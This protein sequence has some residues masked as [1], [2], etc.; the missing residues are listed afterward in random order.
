MN[1]GYSFVINNGK[2]CSSGGPGIGVKKQA[3][4]LVTNEP[5]NLR[6]KEKV[7]RKEPAMKSHRNIPGVA[8]QAFTL[9]EL[10]VVMAII[11][12]LAAL[13]LPVLSRAK[14]SASKAT[15]LNNLRQIMVALHVYTADDE[16]YLPPPNWDNGNATGD[17]KAHAGWLYLPDLTAT[18]P[19]RFKLETG[20]LWPLLRNAKIYACPSD[21]LQMW[22]YSDHDGV[23]EQRQ[24]QLSSYA[25]NGAVAGFMYG[26][27]HPEVRPVKLALMRPDD[28]AFWETDETEPFY[29]N[30]GANN[31]KEGVSPRHYQG[32][33]Q[34]LFDS[35]ANYV[36][37]TDWYAD[38]ACTNKNRLWCYPL[39]ADGR[40]P[41]E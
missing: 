33:I 37:L 17:G 31:P 8:L 10:L 7:V 9:I 5:K 21:D 16:D 13:L 38:V 20:L 14:N 18:G 40:D 26:W 12:I 29:F 35:S 27:Y 25:M 39:S 30:D 28:C 34:A 32:G 23:N 36:K 3:I 11:A 15:D 22:H 4:F 19:D 24:Q 2:N 41:G 6:M 1:T